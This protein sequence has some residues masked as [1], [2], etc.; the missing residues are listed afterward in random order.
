MRVHD[1]IR[2]RHSH[3]VA[4]LDASHVGRP[5]EHQTMAHVAPACSQN[6]KVGIAG[7]RRSGGA[8]SPPLR[9]AVAPRP[10]AELLPASRGDALDRATALDNLSCGIAKE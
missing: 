7:A 5:C 10:H 2:E 4:D 1:A 3:V 8:R 6:T 9:V